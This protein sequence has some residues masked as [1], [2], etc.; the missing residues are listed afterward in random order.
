MSGN[1]YI[2]VESFSIEWEGAP[3]VVRKGATAREGHPLVK[4]YPGLFRPV[5]P[6]FEHT[7]PPAPKKPEPVKLP[8]APAKKAAAAP[9]AAKAEADDDKG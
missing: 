1:I 7:P 2:A 5:V 9:A 3:L 6:T 4:K 8:P